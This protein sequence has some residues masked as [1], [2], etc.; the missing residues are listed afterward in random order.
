VP[1]QHTV[2]LTGSVARMPPT[3]VRLSADERAEIERGAAAVGETVSETLRAGGLSRARRALARSRKA[4]SLVLE[5]G[6]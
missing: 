1:N 4:Q 6:T 5:N 2:K 3:P